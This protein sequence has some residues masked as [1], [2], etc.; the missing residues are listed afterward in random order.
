MV[1]GRVWSIEE[2]QG[3]RWQVMTARECQ[4]FYRPLDQ[5]GQPSGGWRPGLPPVED[6]AVFPATLREVLKIILQPPPEE[7]C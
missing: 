3:R 5:T 6:P 1:S 2:T 4:V 7:P